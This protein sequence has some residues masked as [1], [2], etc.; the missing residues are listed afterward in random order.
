MSILFLILINIHLYLANYYKNLW[1]GVI[2]K[3]K[4]H[5]DKQFYIIN[6]ENW[7]EIWSIFKDIK[8][9]VKAKGVQKIK[10]HMSEVYIYQ[11]IGHEAWK[12]REL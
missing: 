7:E 12:M 8:S 11:R 4:N 2:F 10:M 1:N 3:E 9:L 5:N 6:Q